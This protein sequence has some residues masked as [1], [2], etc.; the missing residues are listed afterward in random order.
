MNMKKNIQGRISDGNK[1]EHGAIITRFL[2]IV[3]SSSCPKRFRY[4]LHTRVYFFRDLLIYDQNEN[5]L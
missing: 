4:W 1:V 5:N 2:F 3:L